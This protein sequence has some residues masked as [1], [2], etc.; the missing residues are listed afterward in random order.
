MLKL[1]AAGNVSKR[2]A[3]EAMPIARFGGGCPRWQVHRAFRLPGETIVQAIET[4]EGATYASFARALPRTTGDGFVT[5]VLGC[6]T[7]HAGG[8]AVLDA[9]GA[10]L[11]APT[12]SGLPATSASGGTAPSAPCRR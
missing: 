7:R 9:L 6:E 2:Y 4:P 11:A 12:G 3:G 5:I 8:I 1:D 10:S